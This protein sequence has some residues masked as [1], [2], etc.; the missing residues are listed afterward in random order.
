M[1]KRI[2]ISR[3]LKANSPF[4]TQLPKEEYAVVGCSL[5][6]FSAIPFSTLPDV[7]WIFFYSQKAVT[8]FFESI[9]PKDLQV[10]Y[11]AFG[12]GTAKALEQFGVS[13]DF[14]GTGDGAN[15]AEAFL[16]A[17]KAKRVLFPRAQH[18]QKTIQRLLGKQL[19]VHDLIVYNNE[20]KTD[21]SLPPMDLL[22]FTSPMNAQA[23]FKRYPW[24]TTQKVLAIGETTGKA[25]QELGITRVAIAP[26]ASEMALLQMI[27]DDRNSNNKSKTS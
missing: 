25:L 21:F 10:K 18:S 3:Q 8:F 20:P 19:Q 17:A 11:A 2:F 26:Q 22:I 6:E 24:K 7:D 9:Q 12:K 27:L 16:I 5:L 1:L 4:L 14:C 13:V 15:T 23:Y